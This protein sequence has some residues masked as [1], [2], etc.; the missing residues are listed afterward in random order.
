MSEFKLY[1]DGKLKATYE[2]KEVLNGEFDDAVPALKDDQKV[3]LL[4][5]YRI[6]VDNTKY[7]LHSTAFARTGKWA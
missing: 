4:Q 5:G 3:V 2:S 1:I 7:E 6:K